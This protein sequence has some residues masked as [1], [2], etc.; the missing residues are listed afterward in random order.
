MI[1]WP[2]VRDIE[3]LYPIRLRKRQNITRRFDRLSEVRIDQ[4][5]FGIVDR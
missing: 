2:D 5:C 1:E 3:R 4:A